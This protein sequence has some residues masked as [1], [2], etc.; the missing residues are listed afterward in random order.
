MKH[1]E[2]ATKETLDKVVTAF[3]PRNF[4]GTVVNTKEDALQKILELIPKG[5]SVM[6]GSS[7]TLE[8]MGFVELLK[9]QTYGWVN[10]HAEVLAE[11]DPAKQ[12]ILRRAT[13]V[14]DYYLGSA[15]AVTEAG[16]LF[17][18]SNT[19]SQF[20]ALAFNAQ[21]VILVVG[22]QKIV[23]TLADAYTRLEEHILALEEVNMQQ[24]YGMSTQHNKTLI[25]DGEHPMFGRKIHVILVN[26]VLGF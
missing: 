19:G 4:T 13:T 10:R 16:Q 25:L 20:P 2:L 22:A 12:S 23:P 8:E 11:T 17:F 5:A 6:N 21:N 14:S 9:T 15:H 1:T 26:E 18:A 3:T 24:K 7:R